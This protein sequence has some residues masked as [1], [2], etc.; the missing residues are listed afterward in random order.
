MCD[1]LMTVLRG[2]HCKGSAC[3]DNK[4]VNEEGIHDVNCKVKDMIAGNSE[5]MQFI[6]QGKS[7]IADE[8]AF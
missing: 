5:T 6:V 4:P 8:P 7:E 3:E 1:L 2:L